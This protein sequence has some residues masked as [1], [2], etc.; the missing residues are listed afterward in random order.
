[1]KY[2]VILTPFAND[3]LTNALEWYADQELSLETR[4]Y[5][6][7][8]KIISTISENPRIFAERKKSI[9]AAIIKPFPFLIFYK[10]DELRQRIV[11]LAILHQ[12]R[13]PKIW[14]SR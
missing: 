3:D 6:S 9:R 2:L 11:V 5:A 14:M 10:I 1:M 8:N 4:F 7:V 13:N 12:S